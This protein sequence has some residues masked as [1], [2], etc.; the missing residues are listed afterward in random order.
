MMISLHFVTIRFKIIVTFKEV[1]RHSLTSLSFPL[2]LFFTK[3][4]GGNHGGRGH[5]A[6]YYASPQSFILAL[7]YSLAQQLWGIL[8]GWFIKCPNFSTKCLIYCRC[9]FVCHHR[10][11]TSIHRSLSNSFRSLKKDQTTRRQASDLKK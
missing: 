8:I 5:W 11:H 1:W 10:G 7:S 3:I 4:R 6:V 9:K 2:T